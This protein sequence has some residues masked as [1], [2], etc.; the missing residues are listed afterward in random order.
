MEKSLAS[1]ASPKKIRGLK[2][3]GEKPACLIDEYSDEGEFFNDSEIELETDESDDS[4]DNNDSDNENVEDDLSWKSCNS[5]NPKTYDFK[6]VNSGITDKFIIEDDSEEYDYFVNYFDKELMT[7]IVNE[8]NKYF[9]FCVE[10]YNIQPQSKSKPWV[11]TT[12]DEMYTFFALLILMPH[13]K[14]HSIKDYW[15]KDPMIATE[16]FSKYMTRNR[17]FQLLRYIHFTDNNSPEQNDVMWK[18]THVFENINEKFSKFFTPFQKIAIKKPLILFKERFRFKQY[19]PAKRQSSGIK[20]FISCDCETGIVLQTLVYTSSMQEILKTEPS[21]VSGAVI[22][23]LINYHERKGHLLYTDNWY[24]SPKLALYLNEQNTGLCGIIK[25]NIKHFPKFNK[26]LKHGQT[27]M[28]YCDSVLAI[29]WRDKKDEYMLSTFHNG[30]FENSGKINKMTHKPILKPNCFIDYTKNM[31]LID[32][33][34]MKIS[35]VECVR[36]SIKWYKKVFF[37]MMDLSILN[38]Y[39]MYLVKTGKNNVTLKDF[40]MKIIRQ[41]LEKHGSLTAVHSERNHVESLD[42]LSAVSF[43][44]RHY[45]DNV[46]TTGSRK[47]GQRICHVCSNTKINERKRKCVTTW[48]PECKVG[49]CVGDCFRIYHTRKTF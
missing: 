29:Q 42:R 7:Y 48:C 35:I 18:I 22:K 25:K 11:N 31:K 20:L 8:T 28:K 39:N 46:P 17:F 26:K 12:K 32:K 15:S 6:G 24:T 47:K 2:R 44:E 33:L 21:G 5:F 43:M 10:N 40:I 23:I 3:P 37:H 13:V 9:Q 4:D 36:K 1:S 27:E 45:P 30:H 41:I 38:C 49:L 19:I 16:F 34:D 14:K